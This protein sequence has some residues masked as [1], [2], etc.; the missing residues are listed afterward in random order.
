M[1]YVCIHP[2]PLQPW[3]LS[4]PG[5]P[6]SS[7]RL[8]CSVRQR[9]AAHSLKQS[10]HQLKLKP[11]LALAFFARGEPALDAPLWRRDRRWAWKHS[12]VRRL[13]SIVRQ[14]VELV[15]PAAQRWKQPNHMRRTPREPGT[16]SFPRLQVKGQFIPMQSRGGGGSHAPS[17][18]SIRRAASPN[19][20][21]G[22]SQGSRRFGL[23]AL[24]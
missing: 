7:V 19:A 18:N 10:A 11:G 24:T 17:S 3:P 12:P 23:G 6:A 1:R 22:R 16:C 5:R 14:L 9:L 13:S 2:L 20:A 21:G 4:C 8:E 15:A